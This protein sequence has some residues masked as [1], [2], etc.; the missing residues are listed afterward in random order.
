MRKPLQKKIRNCVIGASLVE[1]SII[2]PLLLAMTFGI[3][4]FSY[5][6]YQFN[7]AQKATQAGA[8]VAS[9]RAILTGIEDCFVASNDTAGTDCANVAGASAWAGITCTGTAT[10]SNCNGTGMAAVL[11]EMQ[12]FFPGLTA[13][14]LEVEFGPTG[15]GYVGRGKPVPSVTVRVVDLSYDYIAIGGLVNALPG[16]SSLG[17]AINISTAQT[18][19]IGEDIAEGA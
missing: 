7:S 6:L 14:N 10:T 19:V 2:A 11:A 17:D 18:T 1:F 13:S 5:V 4:E 16:D 9:S 3:V 12:I 8:R 15:F